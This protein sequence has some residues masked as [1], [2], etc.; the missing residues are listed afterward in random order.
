MTENELNK[1]A[2]RLF[3]ELSAIKKVTDGEKYDWKEHQR[4]SDELK[5]LILIVG[6]IEVLSKENIIKLVAMQYQMRFIGDHRFYFQF[7]KACDDLNPG[8]LC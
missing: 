5:A 6:G 2:N 8:M 1:K 4:I 7:F 3:K